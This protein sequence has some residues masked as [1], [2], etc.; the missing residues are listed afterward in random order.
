ML[1]MVNVFPLL[2]YT[3]MLYSQIIR[4]RT[5]SETS[6]SP[7]TPTFWNKHNQTTDLD[8]NNNTTKENKHERDFKR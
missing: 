3:E 6:S 2:V 5:D 7:H 4:V 1:D 8:L